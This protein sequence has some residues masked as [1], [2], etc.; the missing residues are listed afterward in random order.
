M[1]IKV[2][3]NIVQH[4]LKRL[5]LKQ[6]K[7]IYFDALI[8]KSL[9][10]LD[11]S[12]FS[13]F[14]KDLALSFVQK[15]LLQNNIQKEFIV[16]F[17]NA[18]NE[19]SFSKSIAFVE[20]LKK[21]YHQQNSFQTQQQNSFIGVGYPLIVLKTK[22]GK[23][24]V[25]PLIIWPI[26][27]TKNQ[28]GGQSFL[29]TKNEKKPCH[30]NQTILS[31]LENYKDASLD[32]YMN[33]FNPKNVSKE[34][35][36]SY[37]EGLMK[38]LNPN[39]DDRK[40]GYYGIQFGNPAQI[41]Q[42]NYY[43]NKT[44]ASIWFEWSG[45][46]SLFEYKHPH[47]INQLKSLNENLISSFKKI[48]LKYTSS[49]ISYLDDEQT[50]ILVSNQNLNI[51]KGA[52]GTGKTDVLCAKV[53]QLVLNNRSSVVISQKKSSIDVITNRLTAIGLSFIL[54]FN[55]TLSVENFKK[56]FEFKQELN[57]D[58]LKMYKQKLQSCELKIRQ[59]EHK[60]GEVENIYEKEI[61][62]GKK[63]AEIIRNLNAFK[64]FNRTIK[65][66]KQVFLSEEDYRFLNQQSNEFSEFHHQCNYLHILNLDKWEKEGFS[67]FEISSQ[68]LA[69]LTF[70]VDKLNIILEA[71]VEQRLN[72][73]KHRKN[74]LCFE[75]EDVKIAIVT[76]SEDSLLKPSFVNSLLA[77]VSST[78]KRAIDNYIH[79]NKLQLALTKKEIIISDIKQEIKLLETGKIKSTLV[80]NDVNE[81]VLK[82]KEILVDLPYLEIPFINN[83]N[84]YD[85]KEVSQILCYLSK[86][87]AI[88][89]NDVYQLHRLKSLLKKYNLHKLSIYVDYDSYLKLWQFES[90]K[91]SISTYQE[92]ILNVNHLT[93][94]NYQKLKQE[95]VLLAKKVIKYQYQLNCKNQIYKIEIEKGVSI[96][97]LL[98]M[99][100]NKEDIYKFSSSFSE[101][102]KTV[103]PI[104]LCSPEQYLFKNLNYDVLFLEEASQLK[105]EKTY[106]YLFNYQQVFVFGDDK[107][108]PP[109]D[110]F[111]TEAYLSEEIT[112]T[113]KSFVL[114]ESFLDFTMQLPHKQFIL[115]K[116]YRSTSPNLIRFSNEMFYNNQLSFPYNSGVE[117]KD[118]NEVAI[119]QT[120]VDEGGL[121][122][123]VN[124][125]EVDKIIGL[126]KI[127]TKI[128]NDNS[129]GIITLNKSQRNFIIERLIEENIYSENISVMSYD[130]VQ[131][132]EFDFVFISF[133]YS[134]KDHNW[135]VLNRFY[136]DRILN[137]LFTRAKIQLHIITSVNLNKALI[138]LTKG[139]ELIVGK[140]VLFHFL[141]AR[142]RKSK[143]FKTLCFDEYKNDK[144]ID[145]DLNTTTK[146]H[147]NVI[148]KR[149]FLKSYQ[150]IWSYQKL[151]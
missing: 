149:N 150:H 73:L 1:N 20:K 72:D 15:V 80:T 151:L 60:F 99:I 145:Y 59:I 81:A 143:V 68:N 30:L 85:V 128:Y 41:K 23:L 44:G 18:N 92:K 54:P 110:F 136:A 89:T 122:K 66:Q 104:V 112:D 96:H 126:L 106:S 97:H 9:Y 86:F 16:D 115:E 51:I 33:S 94:D 114:S 27:I 71:T 139:D 39:Q 147:K 22:E 52:A 138:Q 107:Q 12:E 100:H 74:T 87:S 98:K 53:T 25:A 75:V 108:M 111:E 46:M 109:Y 35:L 135:G 45:V 10:K 83:N 90:L 70:C 55:D 120:E 84:G 77:K 93:L 32:D 37:C 26:L 17:N 117:I 8:G 19:Q 78:K 125:A 76:L 129:I 5:Y 148:F 142:K 24:K 124:Q 42:E 29:I 6:K 21:I 141:C 43:N 88:K 56:A 31:N 130:E 57:A 146:S 11:I 7:S 101:L 91:N 127:E 2:N 62:C 113:D 38:Y 105:I 102:F 140:K 67:L 61:Y 69:T 131:G 28:G 49:L 144:L 137:V 14:G 133:V 121:V 40:E 118:D 3:T 82:I 34:Y 13:F 79:C 50:K 36:A 95:S 119:H 65:L 63:Y 132:S 48:N 116:Y 64:N 58:K 123:G 103:F 47:F 4:L 134:F